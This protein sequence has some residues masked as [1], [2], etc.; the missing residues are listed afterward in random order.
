ML[1]YSDI[2]MRRS[3]ESEKSNVSMLHISNNLVDIV[4]LFPN[5]RIKIHYLLILK[6]K[7]QKIPFGKSFEPMKLCKLVIRVQKFK[8]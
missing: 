4:F 2:E 5:L 7:K 1:L 8:Y 6:Q 3:R